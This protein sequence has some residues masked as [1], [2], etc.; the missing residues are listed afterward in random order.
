MNETQKFP[1]RQDITVLSADKASPRLGWI[2]K[3]YIGSEIYKLSKYAQKKLTIEQQLDT[4][5]WPRYLI[6]QNLKFHKNIKE[7]D[8]L[9]EGDLVVVKANP[10]D[11]WFD[12]GV[13]MKDGGSVSHKLYVEAQNG[14]YVVINFNE[15]DREC[16][17][18]GCVIN[19][20]ALERVEF[21]GEYET[22]LRK[23]VGKKKV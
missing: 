18:T 5:K 6:N 17:T 9:K 13:V 10:F 4:R 1:I 22:E 7:K 2:I 15:D 20:R 3:E 14:C 21:K 19:R 11:Y 12:F 8:G 16:W 23:G